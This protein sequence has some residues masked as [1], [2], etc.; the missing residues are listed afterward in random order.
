MS[1]VMQSEPTY[2]PSSLDFWQMA[3]TES[4]LQGCLAL[5]T[6]VRLSAAIHPS[7]GW[8]NVSLQGYHD[9]DDQ[10]V[11]T[12]RI[13]TTVYLTCQRCLAPMAWPLDI[14]VCLGLVHSDAEAARL[15]PTYEPLIATRTTVLADVIEDELLLALPIVAKHSEYS[16]DCTIPIP[17]SSALPDAPKPSRHPFA[18]LATLIKA[19]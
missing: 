19:K 2:L 4:Q 1:V 12:G 16:M 11:I 13:Q 14:E 9:A 10:P 17:A 5:S 18:G 3:S 7:D 6:L 8:V 15:A